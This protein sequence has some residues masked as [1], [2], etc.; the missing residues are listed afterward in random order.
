[1]AHKFV[2]PILHIAK[3]Y[4]DTDL[5]LFVPPPIL[6][7]IFLDLYPIVFSP[8]WFILLNLWSYMLRLPLILIKDSR[9]L[10]VFAIAATFQLEYS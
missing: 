8:D 6:S 5:L 10:P 4:T 7:Q 3:L 1:M 9:Y 2:V